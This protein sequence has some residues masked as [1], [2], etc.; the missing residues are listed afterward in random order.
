MSVKLNRPQILVITGPTAVG[1][2]RLAHRLA[3]EI[4]GEIINA[5]SM[6]VYRYMDIGT[7]KPTLLQQKELPYHLIDIVEPDFPFDAS[8]F[9]DRAL[10]IIYDLHERHIPVLVV[11][12]TGLYLRVLLRGLFDCP[13]PRKEIR[14]EW[15]KRAEGQGPDF[16][17]EALKRRD[18]ISA[19]RIH[20]RDLYRLVRA[21]EVLELTGR[22]ISDWQQWEGSTSKEFQVLWIGLTLDRAVLYEK[23]NARVEAMVDMG[24]LEEVQG[25]L[26]RGYTSELKPMK[27]LGYRHLVEVLKG[28]K[29][30]PKALEEIKRD[31]RHYAKRQ[32]TWL[33]K[34][35]NLNW[36]S[37]EEFDKVYKKV[38]AFL[39][40]AL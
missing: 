18:P 30:L 23:I 8:D 1:K 33:S 32:W 37:P 7:A 35:E 10:K 4:G 38:K 25:L 14:D 28:L 21:L 9:R 19:G 36:F 12:G 40:A 3:M 16:L 11:G 15:K 6:Q 2:S 5:D 17:W 39:R 27:S 20:Q 34:E 24:F 29:E 31:T 13:K 26:D 22:P